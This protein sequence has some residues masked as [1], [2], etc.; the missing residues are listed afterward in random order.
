MGKD[1]LE[2]NKLYDNYMVYIN[3][4]IF[5]IRKNKFLS[6]IDNGKGYKK[7]KLMIKGKC[8]DQY[9][10]RLVAQVFIS[11]PD[12]KR[13]VNHLDGNKAN[14]HASNLEWCTKSENEKYKYSVNGQN[15]LHNKAT[16]VYKYNLQNELVGIFK[17]ISFCGFVI[18]KS[19]SYI[20][21]RLN[22]LKPKL[23]EQY[24]YL[25]CVL[26]A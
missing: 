8:K 25:D 12:N 9:V 22:K 23:K 7:V 10:H 26:E 18:G 17:S 3:G 4:D 13:E 24:I 2:M 6:H 1:T 15:M 5:S 19:A 21:S 11:N 14:N 16:I 20:W